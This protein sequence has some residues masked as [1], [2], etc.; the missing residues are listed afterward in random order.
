[1]SNG[2]Y[3]TTD[4]AWLIPRTICPA[5]KSSFIFGKLFAE[6]VKPNARS[7]FG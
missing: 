2:V 6:P 3:Q 1:M 4:I 7:E 5:A